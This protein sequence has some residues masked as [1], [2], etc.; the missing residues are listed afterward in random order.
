MTTAVR[1]RSTGPALHRIRDGYWRVTAASGAVLGYVEQVDSDGL[2][3]FRAK[4]LVPGTTRVV[5]LGEFWQRDEAAEC[6]R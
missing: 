2:I 3:R 1:I 6:L 4:H 5:E